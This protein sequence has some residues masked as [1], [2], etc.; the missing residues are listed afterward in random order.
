V[1]DQVK[2]SFV[3][4]TSGHSDA[5]PWVSECPDV[6]NYKWR[7]TPVWHRM[8]YS[9]T[10]MATVGF[11]GLMANTR[12]HTPSLAVTFSL[13]KVITSDSASSAGTWP[14]TRPSSKTENQLRDVISSRLSSSCGII[15]RLQSSRVIGAVS[16]IRLTIC[17]KHIHDV[18]SNQKTLREFK[19]LHL[20]LKLNTH[21]TLH[22]DNSALVSCYLLNLWVTSKLNWVRKILTGN[23]LGIYAGIRRI[24]T[25]GVFWQHITDLI[26]CNKRVHTVIYR[27]LVSSIY[28]TS[29]FSNTPLVLTSCSEHYTNR[30]DISETIFP[31]NRL[32]GAM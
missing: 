13:L 15:P 4:L 23:V 7:L 6:E 25:S 14:T 12:I 11:K 18:N 30:L 22:A 3:I 19:P 17:D 1:P 5:Q 26:C 24:P 28:S 29:V 32:T 10:H 20:L 27:R 16:T 2:P 8:L 31:A 9:R 21:H